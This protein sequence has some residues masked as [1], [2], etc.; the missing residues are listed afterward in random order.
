MFSM[1]LPE[2]I[3]FDLLF[4]LAFGNWNKIN[5]N[6]HLVPFRY[7]SVRFAFK[8]RFKGVLVD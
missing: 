5:S 3:S 8:C 7:E 6:L 1:H 2:L 4:L